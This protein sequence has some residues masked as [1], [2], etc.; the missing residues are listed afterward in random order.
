V[1]LIVAA[2]GT[3][4]A[5]VA[6][7][8]RRFYDDDPIARTP[9][10]RSAAG[11]KPLKIELFFEYAY[12]LFVTAGRPPSNTRAGNLNTVDEVP[13]SSWFTNRVGSSPMTVVQIARGVNS[14]TPPAAEKWTL[15]REKSA[16]TNPGFTARDANGQTWFLQFDS[17]A[18]PQGSSAAVEIATKLF[19]ALGYNQVET[20]VTQ[21]DPARVQI[22]EKATIQR[23]SGARTPFT[24]DDMNRI[25][26][27]AARN[28]DGTYRASAGRML[29]GTVLGPFRYA[30]TR[31]D[32]PND[33]V[34]H[35]HRRE[36]RALRV[37]GAWTNLVDW[38]A[39]NT[40]DTLI[41][42]NGRTIV[43]HYLQDVG[44]SLGM[45][46]N[47]H[48]WDM[49][50]EYYY[51]APPTRKRF[52]TFGF[53]LS[54]W[55]TVPY[56][57]Y[58]SV[59]I[60]EGDR[61]D[62]TTWKPQTPVTAYIEL[63]A[64]DA[65]WAARRVVAFSDDLIRAAVHTGEFSDS[66][67]EAHLAAVL[68]K[69]R[70]A[71]GRAYLP[72]INPIVDPRLDAAGQLTFANAAV[73]AGV[74]EAPTEYH[75]AWFRFDNATAGTQPIGET[76]GATA[77]MAAPATLSSIAQGGFVAID[78][79]AESA[80]HP[81][82]RQPVRAFFRRSSAGWKLVGLERLPAAPGVM[83]PAPPPSKAAR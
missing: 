33:L 61:F 64:D 53:A 26:E 63:R 68:I 83:P 38:K 60:F 5:T 73:A 41:E 40:L 2:T 36:L 51:D 45:A 56:V 11:A 3:A 32:D 75:A 70:D 17:T 28:A 57:E 42:E 72:A 14:D 79:S 18:F 54:P 39:G 10:S 80:A 1:L 29:G 77:S 55:Q 47:E 52:L 23:P 59:N 24:R 8:E 6:T 21:F 27:R 50:W 71:I 67:A 62:P 43:K 69:R 20:F 13:D 66:A 78:L 48:E 12:N 49:G 34:P 65:F 15:L 16:G 31:S 74:A 22:D 25:L 30:G 35:E 37:F 7:S 82:W 46:N 9:E 44:S 19:W 4:A 76:R 58:P 81:S